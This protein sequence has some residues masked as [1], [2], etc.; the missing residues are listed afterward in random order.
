MPNDEPVLT[1]RRGASLYPVLVRERTWRSNR[2]RPARRCGAVGRLRFPSVPVMRQSA[3]AALRCLAGGPRAMKCPDGRRCSA[4]L[5]ALP[6][7]SGVSVRAA[8]AGMESGSVSSA[9]LGAAAGGVPPQTRPGR[10]CRRMEMM[11]HVSPSQPT[12]PL[13]SV[14]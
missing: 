11:Q 9:R 6:V 5:S 8:R 7:W 10:R 4:M 1:A 3:T 2:A 12:G 14:R 13:T